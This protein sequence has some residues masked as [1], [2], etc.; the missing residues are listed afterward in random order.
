[1]TDNEKRAHDLTVA[2]IHAMTVTAGET[3]EFYATYMKLYPRLVEQFK[4]DFPE[5]N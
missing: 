2:T 4:I 1:M 3:P 5:T